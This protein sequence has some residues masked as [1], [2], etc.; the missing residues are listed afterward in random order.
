MYILYSIKD[1]YN[2][3]TYD[4]DGNVTVNSR[5]KLRNFQPNNAKL[6]NEINE[7]KS[8]HHFKEIDDDF[9]FDTT[10]SNN[11]RN[12][13]KQILMENTDVAANASSGAQT[14]G[15]IIYKKDSYILYRID[16]NGD[17]KKYGSYNRT[18]DD[19][20]TDPS[21]K[22]ET[23]TGQYYVLYDT[24]DTFIIPRYDN[25][26]NII[27]DSQYRLRNFQPSDA[28][29]QDELTEMKSNINI[30]EL[31]DNFNFNV[32]LSESQRNFLKEILIENTEPSG[33][34]TDMEGPYLIIY[35]KNSFS[36]YSINSSGNWYNNG[37]FNN[38]F[39]DAISQNDYKISENNMSYT[40]IVKGQHYILYYIPDIFP[41]P[42]YDNNGNVTVNSRY[43]LRNFQPNNAKLINEIN[44]MKSTHSF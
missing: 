15:L 2:I 41:V 8:T 14:I 19:W 21:D 32:S 3:P 28:I 26:G 42:N 17:W 33:T 18:L 23:L 9:D 10:L 43:K 7:M 1:I 38:S 16:D 30:K 5:Y 6:I 11:Q 13:L 40:E 36:T 24:F 20:A 25:I 35:K 22:T 44:E 27:Q 29:L 31:H 34:Q 39:D 37:N 12:Y 4:N